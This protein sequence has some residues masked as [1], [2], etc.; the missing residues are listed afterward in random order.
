VAW[1]ESCHRGRNLS[2]HNM[3]LQY[4]YKCGESVQNKV[5]SGSVHPFKVRQAPISLHSKDEFGK[6]IQF[7]PWQNPHLCSA[8]APFKLLMLSCTYDFEFLGKIISSFVLPSFI[9]SLLP[10]LLLIKYQNMD[11]V[12]WYVCPHLP[13]RWFT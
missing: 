11:V 6:Q 3:V 9:L 1:Q 4:I 7:H 12:Q 8:A 13:T 10:T 2:S 5:A